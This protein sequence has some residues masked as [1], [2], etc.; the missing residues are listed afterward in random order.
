MPDVAPAVG[1]TPM[2]PS[3]FTNFRPK[4]TVKDG[5]IYK[6]GRPIVNTSDENLKDVTIKPMKTLYMGRYNCTQC[7]APQAKLDPIVENRFQAQY[8]D[9]NGAFR[10]SWQGEKFLEHIKIPAQ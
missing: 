9:P 2:P 10:S 6:D 5:K 8:T 3:H 1:A 4:T 7:H